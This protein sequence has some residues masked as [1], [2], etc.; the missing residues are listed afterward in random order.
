MSSQKYSDNTIFY[1]VYIKC[2]SRL[3][4]LCYAPERQGI[5]LVY[6]EIKGNI[7]IIQLI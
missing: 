5:F 2:K 7:E 1:L 6:K 4:R 3:D